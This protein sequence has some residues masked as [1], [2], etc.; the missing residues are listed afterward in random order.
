VDA[1]GVFTDDVRKVLDGYSETELRKQLGLKVDAAPVI[2]GARPKNIGSGDVHVEPMRSTV[3]TTAK[4]T[5]TDAAK[6]MESPDDGS[7]E[8]ERQEGATAYEV[9]GE[10]K[11][12]TGAKLGWY[13]I[14]RDAGTV[15]YMR[16]KYF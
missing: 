5:A 6:L 16:T 11:A 1:D 14:R 4:A 8:I 9:V 10:V 7:K 2:S 15:G 13:M 12:L 3:K